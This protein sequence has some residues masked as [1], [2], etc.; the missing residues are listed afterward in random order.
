MAT[1]KTVTVK[2]IH[3][4]AGRYRNQ[5]GTLIGSALE[6]FGH[7]FGVRLLARSRRQ[8]DGK[9]LQMS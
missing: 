5:R 2:Q 7:L 8:V 3:S 9:R 4:G 6:F 1:K